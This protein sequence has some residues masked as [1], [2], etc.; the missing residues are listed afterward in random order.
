MLLLKQPTRMAIAQ[1]EASQRRIQEINQQ[2][3][4]ED[5]L[6]GVIMSPYKN[7]D[8]LR[9]IENFAGKYGWKRFVEI[10]REVHA[11]IFGKEW[12]GG[13]GYQ[14]IEK[15]PETFND[16]QKYEV[17]FQEKKEYDLNW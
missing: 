7:R 11:L 4:D 1:W 8:Y 6:W 17:H 9:I 13:K 16:A 14:P 3:K 2:Q 5:Y 15:E 12:V 10:D